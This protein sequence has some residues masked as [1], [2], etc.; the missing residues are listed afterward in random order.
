MMHPQTKQKAT[1]VAYSVYEWW[2]I[3]QVSLF[4]CPF[5]FDFGRIKPL[6]TFPL[7]SPSSGS[8]LS[9]SELTSMTSFTD[10]P[11]SIWRMCRLEDRTKSGSQLIENN[12]RPK[13]GYIQFTPGNTGE[14]CRT[15]F[16]AF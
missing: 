1:G 13:R 15:R 9:I 5:P 11:I 3:L 7:P 6:S 14:A 2:G 10:G 4:L 16:G 12:G 8:P